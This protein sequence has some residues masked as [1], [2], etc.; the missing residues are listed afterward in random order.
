[1][2]SNLM[3]RSSSARMAPMCAQPRALPEPSASPMRGLRVNVLASLPVVNDFRSR[4]L[5]SQMGR[6][7]VA[8]ATALGLEH[9]GPQIIFVRRQKVLIDATLAALYGVRTRVLNQAVKRNRKDRKS[10]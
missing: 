7:V 3:P 9:I 6:N 8:G 5:A 2:R 1:M 10:V 4:P